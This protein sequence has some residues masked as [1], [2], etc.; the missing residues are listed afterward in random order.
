MAAAKTGKAEFVRLLLDAGANAAIEFKR[1]TALEVVAGNGCLD[2]AKALVEGGADVNA[3]N[4]SRQPPVH[5]AIKNGHGEVAEFLFAQGYTWPAPPPVAPR[6]AT[7]DPEKGEALFKK[8]CRKCHFSDSGSGRFT[9]PNLWD[10]VGR[11]RA[12]VSGYK[13]SRALRGT[14]G[15]WT[16]E[17]LNVF[18]SDP[19]RAIPGVEMAFEGVQD[20]AGRADI[21]AFLRTRSANPVPL[22]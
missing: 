7:A 15:H 2:C 20:D 14:G 19:A 18:I 4:S 6:L 13:Y 16:F 9:G 8:T 17:N 5:F 1:Q 22:P 3:L 12:N 11:P 10:V 21:I